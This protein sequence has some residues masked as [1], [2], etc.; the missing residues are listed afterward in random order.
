MKLDSLHVENFGA[1]HNFSMT[2]ESG[3][4]VLYE[5][6]GWGKSTLAAFIRV[7]LYGF[8]GDRRRSGDSERARFRP[9]QGGTFGGTLS[10]TSDS[11]NPY[12]IERYFGDKRRDDI[13]RLYRADTNLESR[14][15]SSCPGEELFSL[16]AES[17]ERTVYIGQGSLH[18]EK[19]GTTPAVQ[20]QIGDL[21]QEAADMGE[22]DAAM[23]RIKKAA[24]SLSPQRSSGRIRKREDELSALN[25][26]AS[27]AQALE[28]AARQA[29]A[30]VKQNMQALEHLDLRKKELTGSV[31]KISRASESAALQAQYASI[32]ARER[33][34]ESAFSR[35]RSYF[36]GPVPDMAQVDRMIR[37]AGRIRV[38]QA[39]PSSPEAPSGP[40]AGS[41]VSG[42]LSLLAP[43]LAVVLF[44]SGHIIPA[45]TALA[46]FAIA[47]AVYFS[48]RGQKNN[49]NSQES[50]TAAQLRAACRET[51]RFLK[52][53]GYRPFFQKNIFRETDRLSE[54]LFQIRDRLQQ[55]RIRKQELD[56]VRQEKQ[57]FEK[58][59]DVASFDGS[60]E[61]SIR[62]PAQLEQELDEVAERTR[63]QQA[64][65]DQNHRQLE[66]ARQQL[67]DCREA[68]GRAAA[69]QKEIRSLREQ[70]RILNLT[71]QYLE[72]ARE[73][74]TGQYMAPLMDSFTRYYG[75]I[76]GI[77]PHD[78]EI[79]ADLDIQS[80]TEGA[81]RSS[82]L[83]SAGTQDLIAL[84][85]RMAIIDAMYRGRQPFVLLDDPFVNF[86]DARMEGALRFLDEIAQDRQVIYLTCQSA[87]LP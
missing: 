53:L 87:R 73:N 58:H 34:A 75:M 54:S 32:T 79:N 30:A 55:L 84:C 15:F 38:M 19:E 13:F 25:K 16:D 86:D 56:S 9:W 63:R 83:Q 57:S 47:A 44:I 64:E 40:N 24:S 76:A 66:E 65:L 77:F 5:E 60:R 28:R 12:R 43:I 48:T 85:R 22:Y 51:D 8:D 42:V 14:D 4:N 37:L 62:T 21:T 45:V 26:T 17:F 46:V 41:V 29:D 1:L 7:M 52:Q 67:Q 50:D 59:F 36:P 33:S 80:R 82:R 35:C 3:I 2:F 49:S 10:F 61:Q 31:S 81:L 6:N 78:F 20:A 39:H 11:G 68:A 18:R 27:R 70:Y 23:Q 74:F 72:L 71:A 69:L